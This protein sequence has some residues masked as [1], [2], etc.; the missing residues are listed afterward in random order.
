MFPPLTEAL[1]VKTKLPAPFEQV[2]HAQNARNS[3]A[4]FARAQA[5]MPHALNDERQIAKESLTG[6]WREYLSQCCDR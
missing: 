5:P 4:N 6:N 2:R 3:Y 1:A